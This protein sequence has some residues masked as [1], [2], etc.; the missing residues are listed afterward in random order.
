MPAH[1]P[2]RRLSRSGS[3]FVG[4]IVLFTAACA[5]PIDVIEGTSVRTDLAAARAGGLGFFAYPYPSDLRLEGEGPPLL[6]LPGVEDIPLLLGVAE[7]AAELRGYPRMSV[8]WFAFDGPMPGFDAET[9]LARGDAATAWLVDVDPDS[10]VRGETVPLVARTLPPDAWLAE[11]M[12]ALAPVPGWVL[13]PD[14]TYAYVVGRAFGDASGRPLGSPASM[15]QPLQGRDPGGDDGEAL[16]A[17]AEPLAE[18]LPDLGLAPEDVAAWTTFTTGDAV[19]DMH[20]LTEV[21]RAQED[22]TLT[23]LRAYRRTVE[24]PGYCE[25]HGRL[26][27]PEFQDGE[28]PYDTGGRFVFEGGVPVAQRRPEIPIVLTIPDAPMPPQGF[29]LAM[30]FHGSGGIATQLVDRGPRTRGGTTMVGKGPAWILA[31]A[32]F[33]GAGSAH[34]VN[35]QRVPGASAIEYLNF[36]NLSAFRDTFRQGVIEQRLYLDALLA[37]RM[38]PALVAQDCPNLTLPDGVQA[39]TFDPDTVVAMG[40]SMGGMYTNMVGAVEPRIKA[41]VPTGAGGHWTR[42]ILLTSLLGEGAVEPLLG[43]LLRLDSPLTWMHPVLHTAQT[44]W[45]PAEPVAYTPRLARRPLPGHPV[46]PIYQPIGRGD[47]YFPP[48]VFDAITLASGNTQAG[49][50]VWD[51]LQDT[52]ALADLD[53][54]EPYPVADN[55]TSEDGTPYTGVAVQYEGDGF[56]DPHTIYVQLDA[57]MHQYRCFFQTW[58]ETG[59]AVVPEG[60]GVDDGCEGP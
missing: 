12:L 18:V 14:T 45:E 47:S 24:T 9:L 29:P 30:Y 53:G 20:A 5:P 54:V 59:T 11:P 17:E 23:D 34:P 40:Q 56:S 15:L 48:P 19:A 41:V 21:V 58:R 52:L 8:A 42:F 28:P 37:M 3:A 60:G 1:G 4:L 13:R 31:K 55:L 50:A 22:P 25:V 39:V 57:V 49:D 38:D 16:R 32:G 2:R 10:P 26:Q 35:P 7:T 51:T 27:V 6:G 43:G 33:A 36:F 46:R 44:A